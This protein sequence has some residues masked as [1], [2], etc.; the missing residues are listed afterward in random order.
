[1]FIGFLSFFSPR[2]FSLCDTASILTAGSF[3]M[4]LSLVAVVDART[5]THK[6]HG[7][8]WESPKD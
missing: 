5:Q 8:I 4:D 2:N 3:C 1:M 6:H 7:Y